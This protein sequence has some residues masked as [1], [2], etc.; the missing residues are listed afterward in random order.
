MIEELRAARNAIAYNA[1]ASNAALSDQTAPIYSAT[2]CWSLSMCLTP[3]RNAAAASSVRSSTEEPD[4]R[5]G[6][7]ARDRAAV[8][9][10]SPTDPSGCRRSSL[11]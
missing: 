7:G 4:R 2:L 9:A 11:S 6:A 1:M 10:P 5:R 8:I 3:V